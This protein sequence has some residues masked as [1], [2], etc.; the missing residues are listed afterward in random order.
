MDRATRVDNKVKSV[1]QELEAELG[2]VI[3]YVNDHVV[4][5]VRQSSSVALR[6]AAEQL[7]RAAEH[8]DRGAARTTHEAASAA[9]PAAAPCSGTGFA[10]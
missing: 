8:L 7:S 9:A 1:A 3:A 2:R 5:E 6:A 4:P 10:Q